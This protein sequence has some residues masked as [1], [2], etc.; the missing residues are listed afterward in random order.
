MTERNGDRYLKKLQLQV[1]IIA[2]LFTFLTTMGTVIATFYK[3]KASVELNRQA[4]EKISDLLE[5]RLD[6]TNDRINDI[7][8]EINRHQAVLFGDGNAGIKEQIA[9]LQSTVKGLSNQVDKLDA[10]IRDNRGPY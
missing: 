7:E 1:A 6:A 3:L 5:Q 2:L 10:T 9:E 8:N 4:I